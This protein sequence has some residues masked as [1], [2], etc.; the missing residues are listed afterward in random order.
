MPPVLLKHWI[1]GLL[2]LAI[3]LEQSRERPFLFFVA[4]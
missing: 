1:P 2:S 3:T 4:E